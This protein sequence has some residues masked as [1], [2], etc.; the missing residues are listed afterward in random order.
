LLCHN[1]WVEKRGID[2]GPPSASPLALN[3]AQ[4]NQTRDGVNQLAA[5]ERLGLFARPLPTKPDA[6]PRQT[7]PYDPSAPLDR[8]ARSY[9]QINCAHC[10]QFG[11]GGAANIDLSESLSLA[12]TKTVGVRPIQ[13]TFGIDDARIITPGD[14]NRSVLI[15]RMAKQGGG[16]MPRVGSDFVDDK[17]VALIADWITSMRD[18][19]TLMETSDS[20]LLKTILADKAGARLHTEMLRRLLATTQGS[21]ALAR[22][23]N[24]LGP[25]HRTRREAVALAKAHPKIEVRDLFER[26]MPDAERTKRLGDTFKVEDLLAL[27]GDAERGGR[28]FFADGAA[29]C[30]NCHRID[31]KGETLG[32]D[33][34]KIGAKYGKS[35]LLREIVEPSRTIEPQYASVLLETKAG[36]IHSGLL[37]EKT[38]REVVLKD[39]KNQ[40]VRIPVTDVERLVPQTKSLMPDLLLRE[41]TAQQAAD[42]LEFLGS[43]K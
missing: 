10:H 29:Q 17:G 38:T 15:Y 7:N 8:R 12:Q 11:A 25:S 34:S 19:Q 32:P 4:L 26:F 22:A 28:I 5:F 39:A 36:Q 6:L 37:V 18:A 20:A 27:R 2:F 14:P 43:L 16:R 30:K 40:P 9:L 33:L 21:L 41:L 31:G 42:L 1:P 13:G 35:E 24:D 23:I 3:S